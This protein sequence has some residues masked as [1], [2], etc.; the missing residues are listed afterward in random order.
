[1]ARVCNAWKNQ[2]M[3]WT[4]MLLLWFVL[5]L[6]VKERWFATCNRNLH[7]CVHVSIPAPLCFRHPCNWEMRQPWRW[8]EI[9]ANFY[10]YV[11][12]KTITLAEK[13]NNKDSRKLKR[14]CKTLFKVKRM[15]ISYKK[16]LILP[17]IRRVFYK[18]VSSKG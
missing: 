15:Q 9:P 8:L 2:P 13:Q 16:C 4:R 11:P 5:I 7:D 14:N 6:T 12:K 1:M 18:E 17:T 3:K 10:F